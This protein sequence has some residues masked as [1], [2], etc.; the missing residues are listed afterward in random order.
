M[1]IALN[2]IDFPQKFAILRE[3]YPSNKIRLEMEISKDMDRNLLLF[4]FA[5]PQKL[6][7]IEVKAQDLIILTEARQERLENSSI[8]ALLQEKAIKEN[9]NSNVYYLEPKSGYRSKNMLYYKQEWA[10]FAG[11]IFFDFDK[12]FDCKKMLIF[13]FY[14]QNMKLTFK[15]LVSGN[16]CNM[17]INSETYYKKYPAKN[18]EFCN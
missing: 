12:E 9:N 18:L 8:E 5:S 15:E 2:K 6:E 1:Q 11:K 16:S 17:G 7:E 13:S 4:K 14:L 3:G 10:I